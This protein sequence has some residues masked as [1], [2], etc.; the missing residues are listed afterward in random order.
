MSL[1]R[2]RKKHRSQVPGLGPGDSTWNGDGRVF[3]SGYEEAGAGG[4]ATR[5]NMT[6]SRLLVTVYYSEVYLLVYYSDTIVVNTY[7]CS[8]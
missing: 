1:K 8:I 4:Q 2:E 7:E 3:D 5:G 6:C